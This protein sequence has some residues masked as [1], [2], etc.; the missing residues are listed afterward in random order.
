MRHLEEM[1]KLQKAFQDKFNFHP[2]LH[3][4]ASAIMTEAGE[5]WEASGGKWWSKKKQTND[6][7][8]EELVDIL[9]FF[10]MYCVEID[11]SV[12]ELFDEYVKKLSINYERQFHGY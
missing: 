4:V 3:L 1:L 12:K 9:H 7:R 6:K 2:A 5:L 11:I 8:K 10:L